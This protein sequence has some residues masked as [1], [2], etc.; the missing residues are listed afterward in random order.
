MY[1]SSQDIGGRMDQDYLILY[2]IGLRH[3]MLNWV[4]CLVVYSYLGSGLGIIFT[5]FED[6]K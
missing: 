1:S 4:I 2:V 5:V 3:A 6:G